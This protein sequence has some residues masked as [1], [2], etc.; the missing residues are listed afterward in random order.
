MTFETAYYFQDIIKCD[1]YLLMI[2]SSGCEDYKF[3]SESFEFC[4]D[5]YFRQH[6]ANSYDYSSVMQCG[7]LNLRTAIARSIF[8][9]ESACNLLGWLE[10]FETQISDR[11]SKNS[12]KMSF[13]FFCRLLARKSEKNNFLTVK[14]QLLKQS[15]YF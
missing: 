15:I 3:L 1:A 12:K 4:S 14:R 9:D 10:S 5:Y 6:D 13:L 11:V 7:D 2:S 8:S